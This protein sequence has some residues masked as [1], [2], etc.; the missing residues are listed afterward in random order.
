MELAG[1]RTWRTGVWSGTQNK[2]GEP[3]EIRRWEGVVFVLLSVRE[4]VAAQVWK[5]G[6]WGGPRRK[7]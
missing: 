2:G 6:T 3:M 5:A 7:L 4:K 1:A